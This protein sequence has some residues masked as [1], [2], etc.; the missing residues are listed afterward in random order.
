MLAFLRALGYEGWTLM[1]Q[2]CAE[3]QLPPF[4]HRDHNIKEII[5]GDGETSP[6]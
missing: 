5:S 1:R 6:A 2:I 3:Q 4:F